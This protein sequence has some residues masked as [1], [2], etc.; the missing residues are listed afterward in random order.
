M[1]IR[2]I[3]ARWTKREDIALR[4]LFHGKT[5]SDRFRGFRRSKRNEAK[6]FLLGMAP[7]LMTGP[8]IGKWSGASFLGKTILA[9]TGLWMC[10]VFAVGGYLFFKSIYRASRK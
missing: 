9:A 2:K 3:I 6:V 8:F 10:G 4:H 5:T 7:A 1:S